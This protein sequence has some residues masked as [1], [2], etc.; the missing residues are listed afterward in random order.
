MCRASKMPSVPHK[1]RWL[2]LIP[3]HVGWQEEQGQ[4]ICVA[5]TV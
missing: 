3:M 4:G 5:R 1:L 2:G